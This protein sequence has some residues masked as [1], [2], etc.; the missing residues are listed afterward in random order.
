M[1]SYATVYGIL[2]MHIY[3]SYGAVKKLV[4]KYDILILSYCDDSGAANIE[5]ST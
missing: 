2:Y 5:V 1:S 3:G 4:I